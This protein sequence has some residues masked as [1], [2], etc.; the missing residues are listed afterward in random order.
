MTRA[1]WSQTPRQFMRRRAYATAVE[2]VR[3]VAGRGGERSKSGRPLD[4]PYNDRKNHLRSSYERVLRSARA[5]LLLQHN[6]LTAK[7][8]V[9]VRNQIR[10]HQA[11]LT[12]L[13][14][15]IFRYV[16]AKYA[17]EMTVLVSGPTSMITFPDVVPPHLQRVMS[18]VEGTDGRLLLL[19]G[20][21]EAGAGRRVLDVA[22]LGSVARLPTLDKMH[23]DLVGTLTWAAGGQLTRLLEQ[24][25]RHLLLTMEARKKDLAQDG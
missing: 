8:F 17:P 25:P 6:N 23:S 13:N 22:A 12:V 21:I 2:A 1:V 11:T 20:G 4:K 18:T 19:G 24:V 9:Q 7:E 14:S 15:G 3:R 5:I 10:A 16:L